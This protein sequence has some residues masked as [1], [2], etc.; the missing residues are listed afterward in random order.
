L[1]LPV[2]SLDCHCS[3]DLAAGGWRVGAIDGPPANEAQ[4]RLALSALAGLEVGGRCTGWVEGATSYPCGFSLRKVVFAGVV[5][6]EHPAIA[7]SGSAPEI[8]HSELA[9]RSDRQGSAV[10]GLLR[11]EMQRLVVVRLLLGEF[12]DR[13]SAIGSRIQFEMRTVS[14][15]LVPSRFDRATL[16][17]QRS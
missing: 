8:D 3:I 2:F 13:G 10:S 16:R 12:G 15:A 9:D 7:M 5:I 6:G 17:G 11:P 4:L 1:T 14:N